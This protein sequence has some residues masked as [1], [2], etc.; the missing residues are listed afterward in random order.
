[1]TEPTTT[2]G[3]DII[4]QRLLAGAITTFDLAVR[5][6]V[7]VTTIYTYLKGE[8]VRRSTAFRIRQAFLAMEKDQREA[9]RATA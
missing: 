4:N 3:I 2:G 5:S 7:S 6:K 8:K 9:P 1:M